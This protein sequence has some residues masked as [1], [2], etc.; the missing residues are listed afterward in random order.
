MWKDRVFLSV[1]VGSSL[2]FAGLCFGFL[3]VF[4]DLPTW[5]SVLIALPS[6]VLAFLLLLWLQ[7][8]SDAPSR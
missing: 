5:S 1:F 7:I 3:H 2:L 8:A 6:G 4:S